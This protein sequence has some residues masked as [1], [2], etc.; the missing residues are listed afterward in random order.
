ML[1]R[2][3]R[4]VIHRRL[5][6]ITRPIFQVKTKTVK[7]SRSPSSAEEKLSARDSC[8]NAAHSLIDGADSPRMKEPLRGGDADKDEGK[9]YCTYIIHLPTATF[10]F[11]LRAA[12]APGP[13]ETGKI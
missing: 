9:I 6:Y 4:R 7:T 12:L 13:L 10:Q 11:P 8:W 5:V 1:G 2:S 3:E